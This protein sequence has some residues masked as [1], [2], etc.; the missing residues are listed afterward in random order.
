MARDY[1]PRPAE[2]K[3]GGSLI[4]GIM[5][6]LF[7][8]L[9]IAVAIALWVNYSNPFTARDKPSPGTPQPAAE[10][11]PAKPATPAAEAPA[12]TGEKPRFEFYNILP[13]N[14]TPVTGQE[15]HQA[16]TAPSGESYYLQAGAFPNS[17]DAD[18][19]KA[20]LA[21]LGFEAAIQTAEI[22]DKGTWHRVRLG[23]YASLD[24]LNKV[25]VALAQNNIQTSLVRVRTAAGN[26][27]PNNR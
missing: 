13:G 20:R 26:T 10:K 1:K 5:I 19:L 14:E 7:V 21:L 16:P 24:E 3:K 2:Q 12:Q 6:G 22:A 27:Q 11:A 25:R 15:L 8:G 23:P 17:A 4:A 9:A 18:N